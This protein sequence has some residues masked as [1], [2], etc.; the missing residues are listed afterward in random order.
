MISLT[1]FVTSLTDRLT[2][3]GRFGTARAYKS[4]LNRLL[5]YWRDDDIS[6]SEITPALLKSY[7]QYMF[8][9]GCK[10]NTVSL[11]MRMLRSICNQAARNGIFEMPGGLF[12]EVFTG[13]DPSEKRAVSPSVI[14]KIREIELP[15]DSSLDFSRD[16]FLLSFYLR[17]IP[18]VDLIHLRKS[19]VNHGVLRYRRSKTRRLLTVN[20]ESCASEIFRKYA[21]RVKRSPYLLPVISAKG[22]EAYRQYQSALRSYNLHL[23]KLSGL[24]GIKV[25]LTSYVARHSWAT[26]AYRQGIPVAVISESMGH[27]SEKVTYAYLTSFDN[28]TLCHANRKVI[29]LVT[30]QLS[31]SNKGYKNNKWKSFSSI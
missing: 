9:K 20:L 10:R 8:V 27:A 21:S 15:D 13:T 4:S 25:N 6:F 12:D 11:Y 24:L 1:T 31:F 14:R 19:D 29:A 28:R 16:L 17:G 7:E 26:A 22:K 23:H 18:F 5:A 3:S 2:E 30:H